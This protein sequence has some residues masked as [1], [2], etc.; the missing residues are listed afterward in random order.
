LIHFTSPHCDAY[1]V[2]KEINLEEKLAS[3]CKDRGCDSVLPVEGN[4]ALQGVWINGGI[5]IAGEA[6]STRKKKLLWDRFVHNQSLMTSH[7][8]NAEEMGLEKE[9]RS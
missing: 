6:G 3:I 9:F 8:I 2:W 5:M 1:L 7:G 4:C